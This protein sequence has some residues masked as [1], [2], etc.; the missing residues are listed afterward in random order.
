MYRP[1]GCV[2]IN[3][4]SFSIFFAKLCYENCMRRGVSI[5]TLFVFLF[6][7]LV[8]ADTLFVF[9]PGSEPTRISGKMQYFLDADHKFTYENVWNSPG[10]EDSK[11][12]VPTSS[13]TKAT[14]WAKLKLLAVQTA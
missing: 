6:C 8:K 1:G 12:E 2:T 3:I 4:I 5:I 9:N 10:F 14:V 7:G 11:V 13:I